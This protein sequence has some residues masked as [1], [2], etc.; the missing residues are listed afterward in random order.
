MTRVLLCP[1]ATLF[2][3]FI[4]I[5]YV[6]MVM[7]DNTKT[8]RRNQLEDTMTLKNSVVLN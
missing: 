3:F 5:I 7:Q 8:T 1:Q 2:H 6:P 4:F